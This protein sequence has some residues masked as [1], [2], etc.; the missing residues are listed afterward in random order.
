MHPDSAAIDPAT[1]RDWEGVG[2]APDVA[3]PA[4]RRLDEALRRIRAARA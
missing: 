2:T 1:G 3:V 4:D